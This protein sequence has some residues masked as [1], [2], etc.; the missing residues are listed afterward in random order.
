LP[1]TSI[2]ANFAAALS[3]KKKV[4][5][6]ALQQQ[7][8]SSSSNYNSSIGHNISISNNNSISNSSSIGNASDVTNQPRWGET[9]KAANL[10]KPAKHQIMDRL[11]KDDIGY[12]T[13]EGAKIPFSDINR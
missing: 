1:S 9:T 10:S 3:G 11:L 7:C 12:I 13:D 2:Q 6:Q 8:N 4:L 5:K